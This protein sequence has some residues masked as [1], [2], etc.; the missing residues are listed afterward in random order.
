MHNTQQ[1]L[2]DIFPQW[3]IP[4]WK[5]QWFILAS[6]GALCILLILIGF[7]VYRWYI[8]SKQQPIPYW[9]AALQSIAKLQN[10]SY[11][12]KED[13]KRLYFTLT[14]LLKSFME[15]RF[16]VK[17]KNCTD[18]QVAQLIKTLAIDETS[19]KQLEA[20]FT[21]TVYIKFANEQALDA[22]IKKHLQLAA[23]FI[24]Q[25]KGESITA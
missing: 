23:H 15:K 19:K 20:I 1:E 17:M 12:K 3:H 16:S 25:N 10:K 9:Q 4:F 24:E 21:G 6:Y 11:T 22:Q 7:L 14:A 2:Y 18:E 8:R 13:G 5:Q